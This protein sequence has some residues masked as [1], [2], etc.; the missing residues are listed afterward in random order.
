MLKIIIADDHAIVR[1]GLKEIFSEQ[2][3]NAVTDEA[4]DGQELLEKIRKNMYDIVLL[5]ISMP[6]R[7]GL[8]ILKQLKIEKPNIPVL[9]LSMYPEKHYA[10]RILKAGASG[11]LTKSASPEKMIE[12]IIKV[13]EGGKYIS[14]TLAEELA[15]NLIQDNNIP[16]HESL[17]DRE[18][19][20][21]CKLV[22]GKSV[23][24]IAKELYLSVKTIS[25]YRSRILEKMNMKNTIELTRYAL[26]NN[27]VD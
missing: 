16:L 19:Q 14:P 15:D 8:E 26:K 3:F 21:F 4:R 6:G 17:S 11:Y 25:T 23:S 7:N 5:D 10:V 13:S 1:S 22:M 20:V 9:V 18:Y 24:D 2:L 27:L 12:A